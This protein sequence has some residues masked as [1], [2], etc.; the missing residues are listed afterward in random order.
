MFSRR[1]TELLLLLAATPPVLL[2]FALVDAQKTQAFE[3]SSLFVP[4]ALLVAFVIAHLAVR[5]F[6]KNADPGLLPIAFVLSGIG[7]AVVTR[8]DAALAASQVMWLFVGVAGA[9][10]ARSIAVPSLERLAR[11][12]YTLMVSGLVL[13]LLPAFIGREVN[14]AKLWIRFGA[15]RLPAGRARQDPHRAVPRRL[16]RREPRAALG[17]DPPHPRRALPRAAHDGPAAADVGASRWSCSS[18]SATSGR[19]C[20]SSRSSS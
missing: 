19:R 16:P 14:G 2:V 17:V 7:L 12:K 9:C 1:T 10:R 18:S 20:C 6:A 11:Y 13:L 5:Q 4:G 8:L 3:T 15:L